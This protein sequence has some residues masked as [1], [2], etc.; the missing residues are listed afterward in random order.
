MIEIVLIGGDLFADLRPHL[1]TF[2]MKTTYS[3]LLP[4]ALADNL[5][6]FS[7]ISL[8]MLGVSVKPRLDGSLVL[9]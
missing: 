1:S 7:I 2:E 3:L 6:L 5:K 9:C 8:Y 4:L